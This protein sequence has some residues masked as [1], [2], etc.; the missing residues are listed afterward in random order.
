M[1]AV[2]GTRNTRPTC[3]TAASRLLSRPKPSKSI[4]FTVSPK[5][6]TYARNAPTEERRAERERRGAAA[7][8]RQHHHFTTRQRQAREEHGHL[9]GDASRPAAPVRLVAAAAAALVMA[10]RKT[11][12]PALGSIARASLDLKP[13]LERENICSPSISTVFST[14]GAPVTGAIVPNVCAALRSAPRPASKRGLNSFYQKG[15]EQ[16]SSRMCAIQERA[17]CLLPERAHPL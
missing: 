3:V 13:R 1:A 16:I 2:G 5:Q 4:P 11:A 8:C 9:G 14:T 12:G 10:L 15:P 7:W 6:M 17:Q